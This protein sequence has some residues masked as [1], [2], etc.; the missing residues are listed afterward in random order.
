MLLRSSCVTSTWIVILGYMC[1]IVQCVCAHACIYCLFVH[2]FIIC[3]SFNVMLN[4]FMGEGVLV[5]CFFHIVMM[6]S[7]IMS[8][9]AFTVCFVW[10]QCVLWWWQFNELLLSCLWITCI[11][12]V[13]D[14]VF[15]HNYNCFQGACRARSSCSPR[16]C[17]SGV[18]CCM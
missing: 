10:F 3:C 8:L 17:A 1:H 6:H 5:C 11:C 13:V 4:A 7:L 14:N 15:V 16:C 2:F 9:H 18:A 12:N